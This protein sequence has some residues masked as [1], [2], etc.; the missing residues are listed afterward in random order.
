MAATAVLEYLV[1]K[2]KCVQTPPRVRCPA[3]PDARAARRVHVFGVSHLLASLLPFHATVEFVR[4]VQICRL[5]GTVWKFLARMQE[6]GATLPRAALV[7]VAAKQKARRV[8]GG[9]VGVDGSRTEESGLR[10]KGLK[11]GVKG[12]EVKGGGFSTPLRIRPAP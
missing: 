4:V 6:T 7:K 11:G 5:D 8:G 2:Y 3:Q 12:R 10:V 1:R 9:R